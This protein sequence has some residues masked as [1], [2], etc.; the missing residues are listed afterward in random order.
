MGPATLLM[1][2]FS[3]DL[4]PLPK[5]LVS[6]AHADCRAYDRSKVRSRTGGCIVGYIATGLT[7]RYR[8][9]VS[10]DGAKRDVATAGSWCCQSYQTRYLDM[11]HG[12][13]TYTLTTAHRAP[14]SNDS[15]LTLASLDLGT[16]K[17][18]SLVLVP[19]NL[20]HVIN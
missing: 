1:P 10:S 2:A 11:R 4:H 9:P 15:D 19:L 6:A 18:S 7:G 13:Q 16:L 20:F 12:F 5:A 8:S 14:R 17:I 3:P